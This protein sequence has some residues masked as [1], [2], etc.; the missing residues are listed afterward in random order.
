MANRA[1]VSMSLR[2]VLF[3]GLLGLF[4]VA[5][6]SPVS[7]ATITVTTF[8]D[9]DASN[10]SCSLRE[11][12][13]ASNTN[14][15]YRG[16]VAGSGSDSITLPAGTYTLDSGFGQLPVVTSPITV[17]GGGKSTTFLQASTCDPVTLVDVVSGS[18]CTPATYRVLEVGGGGVLTLGGM[19][20][21]HGNC[22]NSLS[23]TSSEGNPDNYKGSGGA[24]FNGGSL[25]LSNSTLTRSKSAS[26]GGGIYQRLGTLSITGTDIRENSSGNGGGGVSANGTVTVTTSTFVGNSSAV[27]GG[28]IAT[29]GGVLTVSSSDFDSN[30]ANSDGGAIVSG[31][32]L[33]VDKST[34][35]DNSAARGGGIFN[36]GGGPNTITNSTVHSNTAGTGGGVYNYEDLDVKNA[37]FSANQG[38]A[39]YSDPYQHENDE[40]RTAVVTLK[41]TILANST[42]GSDCFNYNSGTPVPI[43]GFKNLIETDSGGSPCGTTSPINGIDP[44][45]GTL[46][47][48]P[49]PRYYPLLAGSLAIDGGDAATC[50]AAP[51][52]NTS[53]NGVTRPQGVRCDIGSVEAGG[54]TAPTISDVTNRTVAPNTTTGALPVTVGDAETPVASLALTGTSSNTTLVPNANIVFGGSGAN[55]T[56]TVTPVFS[57]TGAT[58]VTLTV[59]DG[60][61]L[62]ATDTFT[63]TVT[64]TGTGQFTRYLAEGA[65]SSFFDTRLAILNPGNV[66]TTATLTFLRSGTS[67]VVHTVPVPARTR[68]TVDPKTIAGMGNAEFSTT[69]GSSELL[70]I[71]C[72]MLWNLAD[73][74]GAHAETA[75]ASPSTTWYLAE[76]S[77]N[78]GF[79][80]FYLLQNPAPTPSTVRVRYL[81]AVGTPLEKQYVLPANSRTNIWVNEEIFPGTGK[82]LAAADVSAVVESLDATPIIVERAMYLNGQGRTFNAGHES[83]GVTAPATSWFLAEGATG[84]FFDLFVL[85][86]NPN[87]QDAQVRVDYLLTDGRTFTKTMT[88]PANSRSNIWVDYESFDGGV[89]FPLANVAVSTTV[90]STNGVPIIVERAM[91]W[92]GSFATW[93]EGHNSAGSVA[94]GTRWALAD[95]EVG[96]AD[97]NETYILVA[98]VSPFPGN[99][100]VTLMFDDGSS[101]VKDYPLNP[102]SRTNVAVGPDFGAVVA[103]RRFGAVVEST[104]ATPAQIVVER[105]MYSG[106]T[107]AQW[108]A[109]TNAL[110][111]RLQ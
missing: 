10:S 47:G 89:T 38:G 108:S 34:F 29:S 61:G 105:A 99:A 94:T 104:G 64:G 45:L 97:R 80:L 13:I 88:A 22:P 103:N 4:S 15:A 96:G 2:P 79:Q 52:S 56:V 27:S 101:F 77:T 78:G 55:R 26:E 68:V 32:R 95:G 9:E 107:G 106:A 57:Q 100:R 14:A 76:G 8:D 48:A 18:G 81:R 42:G 17:N 30:S 11:A 66:A 1:F 92:P 86:A 21:R 6:V 70:V 75:I 50:L 24:I 59:T 102:N 90:A 91:W 35:H 19:T 63:V 65:T 54:N 67:S 40:F 5:A 53:Q 74:Y 51:V 44:K 25:A 12:I 87:A 69:I 73:H 98:N 36:A 111:T 31:G 46:T 109:G 71:D 41:N 3:G 43:T 60:G 16:C 33:V 93:Y 83:A 7:A 58:T 82:L 39:F 23:C 85:V 20:V 72:T 84:P 62:T 37:T 110:A 49:S 28:A